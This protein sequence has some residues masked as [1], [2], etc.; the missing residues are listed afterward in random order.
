MTW[1]AVLI[2]FIVGCVFGWI[3]GFVCHEVRR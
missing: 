2:A 3:V 1:L